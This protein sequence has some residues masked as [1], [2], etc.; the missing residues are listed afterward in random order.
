MYH[1]NLTLWLFSF[2]VFLI[3]E[4]HIF[5][6]HLKMATPVGCSVRLCSSLLDGNIGLILEIA[7]KVTTPLNFRKTWKTRTTHSLCPENL[8]NSGKPRKTILGFPEFV[9]FSGDFLVVRVI[10]VFRSFPDSFQGFTGFPGSRGGGDISDPK[11][12]LIFAFS[13][14]RKNAKYFTESMLSPS[15]FFVSRHKYDCMHGFYNYMEM[16]IYYGP[17]IL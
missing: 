3:K 10:R 8:E 2:I 4:I 17:R 6:L 7:I 12:G 13:W 15:D 14:N 16:C 1:P 9:G 11:H 5:G